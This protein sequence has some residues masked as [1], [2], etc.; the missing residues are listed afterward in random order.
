M[1]SKF[2]RRKEEPKKPV[3][4]E[5]LEQL[6]SEEREFAEIGAV[7]TGASENPEYASK[8]SDF[9]SDKHSDPDLM[10]KFE[11]LKGNPEGAIAIYTNDY[12]FIEEAA[13]V[14]K[15]HISIERA[16]Q[17]Y[18]KAIEK[19]DAGRYHEEIA[20][21]YQEKGDT[22][23]A[24]KYFREAIVLYEKD[25]RFREFERLEREHGNLENI[26]SM[27]EKLAESN[28]GNNKTAFY[29][30][31]LHVAEEIG[32]QEKVKQ[33]SEK[34]LDV[35]LEN[36]LTFIR[37]ENLLALAN[38][39]GNKDKLITAYDKLI[40]AYEL[41]GLSEKAYQLALEEGNTRRAINI[42]SRVHSTD[43]LIQLAEL[44]IDNGYPHLAIP[45][46]ERAGRD[47]DAARLAIEHGYSQKALDICIPIIDTI[48]VDG[49]FKD[50]DYF[51]IAMDA[52][53]ELYTDGLL[54][55]AIGKK[56]IYRFAALGEFEVSAKFADKLGDTEKANT[57]RTLASLPKTK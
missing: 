12:P 55:M 42:F 53:S 24:E 49:Y 27:Y 16:I 47:K 54:K 39:V 34:I 32:N 46:Y 20:R 28:E 57:Y 22:A 6:P 45:I 26:M 51:E 25:G 9:Y 35:F 56:A 13:K 4:E 21:L 41:V 43:K 3:L 33:I 18:E 14:A 29:Y 30:S 17:V 36:N 50:P 23:N 38:E 5:L 10:A 37:P 40:T 31:A 11:I 15:T 8:A 1:L 52:C 19:Y 2:F 44:S 7:R 48:N